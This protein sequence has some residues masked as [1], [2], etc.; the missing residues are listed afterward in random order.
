MSHKRKNKLQTEPIRPVINARAAGVDIGA[1]EIYAAIS[2]ELDAARPVR[3]F[4]TFTEE[5][6]TLV[7]W[8][9]ASGITTVAME[10]TSVYWIPL[11]ELLEEARIE[12]CLVNPRHV[13]NVPGR[14]TDVQDCQWLQYLHSVGLMRAAFRPPAQVRAIRSLWRHRDGLVRQSA[15]R[16]QHMHKALDQMNLQIH[17]V[18]TDITGKSGMAIVEA[19]LGGE[20]D[21]A[22]LAALGDKRLKANAPTLRAALVGDCRAEHM[23]GL[24]QALEGYRF[25]LQQIAAVD[26]ELEK[27]HQALEKSQTPC[28]APPQNAKARTRCGCPVAYDA[29]GLLREHLGV[30]LTTIPGIN[31]NTAQTLYAELGG[32]LGAFASGKHFASWMGLNPSNKITG[33]KIISAHTKPCGNRVA[34][35]LRMAA[36]GLHHA[37]NE[38]GE[39]Y[40]RM[41]AKL[42][43]AAGLVAVAHKL[44]RI[45]YA[46]IRT[47]RA[48][49]S[50]LLRRDEGRRKERMLAQLKRRAKT[51]GFELTAIQQPA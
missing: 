22:I 45:I 3:S 15:W 4:A 42:G 25:A 50:T 10:A 5:L 17:H 37:N 14:K 16:V 13:K 2:P 21:P 19:L 47:R 1:R 39:Y 51:M 31:V 12:V 44:A 41:K 23:F 34:R 9:Q 46:M 28:E 6:K 33:G 11:A 38:M 27:L 30:D 36:Q 35:A 8:F 7:A 18:I 48:Y 40:R 29:A 43:G 32:D 49:E 20:R 26:M 24:R